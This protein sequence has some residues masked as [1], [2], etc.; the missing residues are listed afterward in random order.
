MKR[1]TLLIALSLTLLFISCGS[2]KK[3]QQNAIEQKEM[4]AMT[5]KNNANKAIESSKNNNSTQERGDTSQTKTALSEYTFDYQGRTI[6]M[7]FKNSLYEKAENEMHDSFS[8]NYVFEKDD[9][10][11]VMIWAKQSSGNDI[12]EANVKEYTEETTSKQ[13]KNIAEYSAKPY[14]DSDFYGFVENYSILNQ[15]SDNY[16]CKNYSLLND[17]NIYL[18]IFIKTKNKEYLDDVEISIE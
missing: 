6:H 7:T 17:D 11:L 9:Y 3:L 14:Y 1:K 13:G 8:D 4:D 12:S 2:E 5:V 10:G 16:Y 18:R 15:F